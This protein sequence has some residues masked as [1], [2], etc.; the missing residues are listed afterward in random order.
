MAPSAQEPL[1][2]EDG[3]K[4]PPSL[5]ADGW[6]HVDREHQPTKSINSNSDDDD[7]D[8]SNHDNDYESVM[9]QS[10]AELTRVASGLKVRFT[11]G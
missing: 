9:Q 3:E 1:D 11:S 6:F 4:H 8:S 10:R 5:N 2:V 7:D